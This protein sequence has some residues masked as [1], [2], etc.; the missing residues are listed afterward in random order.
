MTNIKDLVSVSEVAR[1][2]R[3]TP[4]RV[5]QFINEGR[6][7]GVRLGHFWYMQQQDIHDPPRKPR[8]RKP[9]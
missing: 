9:L 5:R 8:G 6:M 4:A 1:M 7:K 3:V 2:L